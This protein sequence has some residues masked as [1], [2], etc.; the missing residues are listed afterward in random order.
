[1]SDYTQ[2]MDD[3]LCA[4]ALGE[5]KGVDLLKQL[6]TFV[7][8]R[9]TAEQVIAQTTDEIK[10]ARLFD[11][12]LKDLDIDC[13]GLKKNL[14]QLYDYAQT[15]VDE[16]D[17]VKCMAVQAVIEELAMAAFT[18]RYPQ[19]GKDVQKILEEVI[20]DEKRHLEFGIRELNKYKDHQEAREKMQTVHMK[21]AE[22]MLNAAREEN[23]TAEEKKEAMTIMK[24][25]Y[26]L[27]KGRL[28]KIGV[29]L[30]KLSLF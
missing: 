14:T 6:L 19:F 25:A 1:M 15:C 16:K 27:H 22:I 30:P 4:F 5:D 23:L 21:A 24:K 2:L 20:S 8:D 26:I 12:K 11:T 17:W 3:A 29:A 10:H 7:P 18:H 13:N 9:E 28:E